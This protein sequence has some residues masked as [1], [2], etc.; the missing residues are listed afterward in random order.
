[1]QIGM[2]QS[3]SDWYFG[4]SLSVLPELLVRMIT[5]IEDSSNSNSQNW[6]TLVQTMLVEQKDWWQYTSPTG[7]GAY[8]D[9]ELY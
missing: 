8:L 7:T 4:T 9:A 1:M 6:Y 3:Q 2:H 5:S